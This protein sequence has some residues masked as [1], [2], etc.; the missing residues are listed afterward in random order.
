MF[1]KFAMDVLE[2]AQAVINDYNLAQL[3]LDDIGTREGFEM[4]LLDLGGEVDLWGIKARFNDYRA[5]CRARGT[6]VVN[7]ELTQNCVSVALR[8]RAQERKR[9]GEHI[10]SLKEEFGM[11]SWNLL[12][13]LATTTDFEGAFARSHLWS[14]AGAL[15]I[16]SELEDIEDVFFDSCHNLGN[17]YTPGQDCLFDSLVEHDIRRFDQTLLTAAP[18]AGREEDIFIEAHALYQFIRSGA[19]RMLHARVL[20]DTKKCS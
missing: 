15:H 18:W 8:D 5:E 6:A 7:E 19:H 12:G 1:K 11:D 3:F 9:A 20:A 14:C 2:D 4:Y 17:L 16:L 13:N 10:R